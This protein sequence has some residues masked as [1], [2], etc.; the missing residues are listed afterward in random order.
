MP[1]NNLYFLYQ[2]KPEETEDEDED[3]IKT[4]TF[5]EPEEIKSNDKPEEEAEVELPDILMKVMRQPWFPNTKLAGMTSDNIL[6]EMFNV[7]ADCAPLT[8]NKICNEILA[9]HT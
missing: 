4:E 3:E 5:D 1:W 7:M 2:L 6:G 8:Y 9:I